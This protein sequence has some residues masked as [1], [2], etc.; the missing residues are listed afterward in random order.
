MRSFDLTHDAQTRGEA[1]VNTIPSSMLPLDLEK[2]KLDYRLL[3]PLDPELDRAVTRRVA[4]GRGPIFFTAC[5]LTFPLASV[6]ADPD[7]CVSRAMFK[8]NE[9]FTELHLWFPTVLSV[10]CL[11]EAPGSYTQ[12]IAGHYAEDLPEFVL[13]SA[14]E[15]K[16]VHPAFDPRLLAALKDKATVEHGDILSAADRRR[17]VDLARGQCELV[18]ADGGSDSRDPHDRAVLALAQ[19]VAALN[20]L[21]PGGMLVL[22]LLDLSCESVAWPMLHSAHMLFESAVLCKPRTSRPANTEVFLVARTFTGAAPEMLTKLELWLVRLVSEVEDGVAPQ[23]P[24]WMRALCDMAHREFERAREAALRKAL[25]VTSVI[26]RQA[27]LARYRDLRDVRETCIGYPSL[28]RL[29]DEYRA[30][31]PLVGT[32]EILKRQPLDTSS[33]LDLAREIDMI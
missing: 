33:L 3:H 21:R 29:A 11:C 32:A 5:Q 31:Y 26:V 24:G 1:L 23:L 13:H 7:A 30:K 22:K 10:A 9:L 6:T 2:A 18:T 28:Q 17:L 20:L 27:P 19:Y 15:E 14:A 25:E 4:L 8:L 16:D 12:L